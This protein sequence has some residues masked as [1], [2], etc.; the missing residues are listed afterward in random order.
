MLEREIIQQQ[1]AGSGGV[2]ALGS[3]I[4]GSGKYQ[5]NE[6]VPLKYDGEEDEDDGR[7]G[8]DGNRTDIIAHGDQGGGSDKTTIENWSSSI[9]NFCATNGKSRPI[10]FTRITYYAVQYLS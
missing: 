7:G 10:N 8:D 1:S 3:A 5:E 4:L 6:F 2:E 9:D